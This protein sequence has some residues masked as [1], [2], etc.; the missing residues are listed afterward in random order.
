[1]SCSPAYEVVDSD[2]RGKI[3]VASRDLLPGELVV[4]ESEP[5]LFVTKEFAH[6]FELIH[7]GMKVA[8]AAYETFN[9]VLS[10]AQQ[11]AFL[12][13]FGPI[14]GVSAEAALKFARQHT[15]SEKEVDLFVKVASIARFNMFATDEGHAVFEAL[16]RFSHSCAS[17]CR[18]HLQDKQ[19][20]CYTKQSVKTGEELTISYMPCMDTMPT[21]ERRH[22]L[23]ESKEFTCHCPRCDAPGDD[24]RQFDCFN[25]DCKGVM[26]VCHPISKR[27]IRVAGLRYER[28][29]YVEPHLL[30]CTECQKTP[31]KAYQS[32]M[33][34]TEAGMSTVGSVLTERLNKLWISHRVVE[35]ES[36]LQDIIE[37]NY[38]HRHAIA[39]PLLLLEMRIKQALHISYGKWMRY[40]ARQAVREYVAFQE[41]I[42]HYTTRTA[43]FA[44][45]KVCN[46]CCE[47]GTIPVFAAR[48]E[49]DLCQKT[50]RL[51]LILHGRDHR[52]SALDDF[53]A[54]ALLNQPPVESL[55]QC[56][57]CGES[58]LRAA[59]TLSYC[60]RC[61]RVAYCGVGCQ[62][63]H[64]RLHKR[65]CHQ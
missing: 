60:G 16:P 25:P 17:N 26:L 49:K 64:W 33:F 51:Y 53:T 2:T 61:K 29:E 59:V 7:P 13:L 1:M 41:H 42:F 3:V 36:L 32:E 57:F 34:L 22:K 35:L 31:T 54:N 43:V 9:K 24:T 63:A 62:R 50:M 48:E 14:T 45:L 20:W 15:D 40:A 21:H 55:E 52:D 46:L 12:A 56:V 19:A 8:L 18:Y 39:G 28:V 38:P 44:L 10:L 58:P 47:Y 11:D 6:E 23:L 37:L 5:I 65:L 4:K 30:P 27:R